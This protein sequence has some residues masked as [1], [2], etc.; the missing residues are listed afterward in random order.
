MGVVAHL[1]DEGGKLVMSAEALALAGVELGASPTRAST[2]RVDPSAGA[3][4]R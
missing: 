3:S 1:F 4:K 2:T